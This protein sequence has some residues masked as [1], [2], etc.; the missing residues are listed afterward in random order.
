[1]E[2]GEKPQGSTGV[3]AGREAERYTALDL[4]LDVLKTMDVLEDT[5]CNHPSLPREISE[6]CVDVCR[7]LK[8]NAIAYLE[9]LKERRR[10]GDGKWR[11][12]GRGWKSW[13]P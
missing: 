8:E 11:M 4:A 7:K 12:R 2:G 5:I 13:T 9:S 1:M 3:K 10:R 6:K